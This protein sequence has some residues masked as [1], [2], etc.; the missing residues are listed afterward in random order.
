MH[1]LLPTL[2]VCLI[3]VAADKPKSDKDEFQGTWIINEDG[4]S[5]KNGVPL[6]AELRKN[7]KI[8]FSGNKILMK[9]GDEQHMGTFVLEPDKKPKAIT[10]THNDGRTKAS[11]GVY[12][13]SQGLLVLCFAE[14]G[15]ARPR[16]IPKGN[17]KGE[18][19]VLQRAKP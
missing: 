2:T 1:R 6:P 13:F 11:Q 3:L 19:L 9:N 7:L 12:F 4:R 18:Y 15:Q 14:P 10:I 8:T 17:W 5:K 16:E